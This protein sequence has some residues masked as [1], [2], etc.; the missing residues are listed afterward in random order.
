MG[1]EKER[2]AAET[3]ANM[4]RMNEELK[5]IKQELKE[6]E[7]AEAARREAEVA[8]I[9]ERNAARKALEQRRFERAQEARQKIIDAAVEQMTKKGNHEQAVQ[10]KQEKVL[11]DKADKAEADKKKAAEDDWNFTVASRTQQLKAKADAIAADKALDEKL[12]D[13]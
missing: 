9:D 4:Y 12:L 11:N 7:A 3:T 10:E 8:V 5:V 13:E 2:I 1:E 6:Q